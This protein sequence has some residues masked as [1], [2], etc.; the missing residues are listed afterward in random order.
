MYPEYQTKA[1][2]LVYSLHVKAYLDNACAIIQDGEIDNDQLEYTEK[3]GRWFITKDKP[4]DPLDS[5]IEIDRGFIMLCRMME[6]KGTAFPEKYSVIQYYGKLNYIQK[7]IQS[8]T[9]GTTNRD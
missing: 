4:K 6:D 1:N 8:R 2:D 9:D 5:C 3:I 7:E